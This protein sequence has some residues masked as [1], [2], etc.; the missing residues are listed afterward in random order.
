MVRV[1]VCNRDEAVFVDQ[2]S[3]RVRAHGHHLARHGL[4][5]VVV[6]P[7][8]VGIRSVHRFGEGV[9]VSLLAQQALV[10]DGE[11]RVVQ[12]DGD[13]GVQRR[14]DVLFEFDV[15]FECLSKRRIRLRN[16]RRSN[17]S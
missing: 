11:G 5:V 7:L 3:P 10:V 14:A 9:E 4:T 12:G 15:V 17:I 8:A 13:V 2:V 6:A 1:D 16:Q